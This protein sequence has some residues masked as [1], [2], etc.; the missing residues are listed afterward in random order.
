MKQ[1]LKR[2]WLRT[3]AMFAL[4]TVELLLIWVLIIASS[5]IFLFIAYQIIKGGETKFDSMAFA[6]FDSWANP[7][8]TSIFTNI[9]FFAS[10]GFITFAALVLIVY[11]LF[12]EK[13]RWFSLKVPVIAVGSISL[14]LL[15]KYYFNRQRPDIPHLVEA[16]GLSFPSGHSMEAAS[17]Y[18][19]LIY[20]VWQRVH[21]PVLRNIIVAFLVLMILSI[22]SSRVYLH[23]HFATDVL[24]GLSAGA[25]WVILGVS[26]LRRLERYSKRNVNAVVE[27]AAVT[28]E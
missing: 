22:G 16:Q 15:L 26:A 7:F 1:V 5:A 9:T 11:F 10:S 8:T 14:N 12:I 4:F 27:A 28:G 17:F 2:T 20:I 3:L 23:V 6:W 25:L 24:A 19:L 13:H 21:N 18:G